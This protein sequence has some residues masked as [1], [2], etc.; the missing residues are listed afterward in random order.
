MKVHPLSSIDN[1]IETYDKQGDKLFLLDKKDIVKIFNQA[2]DDISN[3]KYNLFHISDDDDE[4][5]SEIIIVKNNSLHL[6]L[7]QTLIKRVKDHGFKTCRL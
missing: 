3:N 5:K 1:L 6:K 4:K 2:K 7:L